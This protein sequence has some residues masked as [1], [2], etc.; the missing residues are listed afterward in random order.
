MT[1]K[2]IGT[3]VLAAGASRR[4][5][6]AKQLLR[7][8]DRSLIQRSIAVACASMC[9]QVVVVLGANADQIT[10]EIQDLSIEIIQ[11]P[12]W[13]IGMSSSLKLGIAT[14][15]SSVDAVII[16]LCDQPLITPAI[17]N[18]L[19]QAYRNPPLF[20]SPIV[21][22]QHDEIIGVPA[23]FDRSIWPALQALEGDTGARKIIQQYR[24]RV[25]TINCP[26]AALDIDTADTWEDFLKSKQSL[27]EKF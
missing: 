5:G 17:I 12:E 4:L 16:M 11:N 8:D 7:W 15:S 6:Q 25:I 3:I 21:A 14:L 22:C 26:E 10:R 23:L 2:K 19:I 13:E 1:R 27:P 9:N 18:Q 20:P 24:N